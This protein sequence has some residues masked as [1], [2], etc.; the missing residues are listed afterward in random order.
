MNQLFGFKPIKFLAITS[1]LLMG[2]AQ[3]RDAANEPPVDPIPGRYAVS[4]S[5][6]GLLK[7]AGKEGPHPFCVTAANRSTFPHTLVKQIYQLHYSCVSRPGQR[8]GNAITGEIQCAADPKLA[9]GANR[10]VYQGAVSEDAVDL[11]VQI[12]F[13]A[14]IKESEMTEEQIKQLKLGMKAMQMMT[15]IIDAERTGEC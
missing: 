4:L 8:E 13:D 12:Q 9:Q 15:F 7:A 3:E 6:S 1:T 11:K 10:F 5:G 2:C 14:T